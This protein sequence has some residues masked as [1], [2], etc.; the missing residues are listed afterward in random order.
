MRSIQNIWGNILLLICSVAITI[1]AVELG[2][3]VYYYGWSILRPSFERSIPYLGNPDIFQPATL[4]GGHHWE[5]R[6]NI[7]TRFRKVIHQTNSQGLRDKEY[8]IKKPENTFRVAVLGDSF[9][10]PSGVAIEDAYHTLLEERFNAESDGLKYEFINFAMDGYSMKDYLLHLQYK[11]PAYEPD[12]IF[13]GFMPGNDTQEALPLNRKKIIPRHNFWAY[14][15]A[16]ARHGKNAIHPQ[17][18]STWTTANLEGISPNPLEK[19]I[20]KNEPYLRRM[21]A[22]IAEES[23]EKGIP[24][25]VANIE[26]L[27]VNTVLLSLLEE[28]TAGHG[29]SFLDTSVHFEGIDPK[30][31]QTGTRTIRQT[32]YLLM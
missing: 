27:T 8:S 10:M 25:V 1:L 28:I 19:M 22:E 20:R 29:M 14:V 23:T 15:L 5:L 3:R 12:L 7:R 30:S 9:T 2:A 6:P 17:V 16:V 21:F 26:Y 24:V 32:V 11:V 31:R 4:V 13:I 18:R